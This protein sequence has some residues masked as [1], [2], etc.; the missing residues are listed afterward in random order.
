MTN[1]TDYPDHD[2]LYSNNA[3]V[4]KSNRKALLEYGDQEYDA[5]N[6]CYENLKSFRTAIDIGARYGG[7]SRQMEIKFQKLIAFEPRDRWLF[8]FPKNIKMDKVIL[9]PIGLG[10][11]N[12]TVPMQGNRV[13]LNPI[14]KSEMVNI[15]TLDSF[16]ITDIDFIKIDV[17][18]YE[19]NVL[20]GG[21]KTITKW[22]PII[23]MEVIPGETYHGELADE[24]LQGLGAKPIERRRNNVLYGW[25]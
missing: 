15:T 18:G 6:M 3:F 20:K 23:C 22:K 16:K 14:H 13:I 1:K 19:L 11:K 21:V 5:Q 24:Y 12:E 8:V 4:V 7:W 10:D 25:D 17:D 2:Y 9:H